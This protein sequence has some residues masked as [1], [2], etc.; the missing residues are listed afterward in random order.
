MSG[1][2]GGAK[3]K[4]ELTNR[5]GH[6]VYDGTNPHVNYEPSSTGGL[7]EAEPSGAAHEPHIEGRL[8]RAKLERESNF[9]QAGERY[10]T[11][12]DWERED[13]VTN[14]TDLLGDCERH[15]QER[16]VG[17]FAQCDAEYGRR[18]A[19][20]LGIPAPEAAGV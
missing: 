19:D 1:E 10:R 14:L 13:L 16:C 9:A 11:M 6:P 20:G 3:S 8:V 7:S 17:L 18:I 12:P 15:I 4:R 5:Q 2:N